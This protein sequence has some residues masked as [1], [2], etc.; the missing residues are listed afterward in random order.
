MNLLQMHKIVTVL[1][2]DTFSDQP[3]AV[4]K[5]GLNESIPFGIE[6]AYTV[7]RNRAL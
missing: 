1:S 3:N 4:W 7:L 6:I 5:T 2:S